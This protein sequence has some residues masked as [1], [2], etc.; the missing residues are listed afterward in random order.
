MLYAATY[1]ERVRGLVLCGAFARMT[2]AED[3]P[4]GYT[5]EE[6]ER[7]KG[8]IRKAWG[9]GASL[10]AI[11]PSQLDDPA[12]VSWVAFAEQEG[13]SPGGALD[14]L[15][16]NLR[17]DL[18]ELLPSIRVP[19]VVMQA[20]QDKMIDPS[21]GPYLA[22]RIPNAKYVESP[23]DDHVF[24]FRTRPEVV[25][26]LRWILEQE[27]PTPEED[28]FLSTVL[29]G[30][31]HG[32]V[33]LEVWGEEVR[34]FRGLTVPGSLQA[35]FDGPIRALRC[36]ATVTQRMQLSCGVH[37]GEVVRRGAITTGIAFAIAEA[38]AARAP[39]GEVWASHVLAD[40]VTGADLA[41]SETGQRLTMQGRRISLLSV[42]PQR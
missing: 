9:R 38:L 24:F 40:L 14:L 5:L 3:Y 42:H 2:H 23:G 30:H 31:G 8:Y 7:L 32:K 16:M 34:R 36:G 11:A 27:R 26:A 17:L 18:R 33:D 1:P 13:S 6:T 29:V 35:C 12:F 10:R 4:C 22:A 20:A 37:T 19:T 21:S 15:E 25:A 39:E 28:R 41:F